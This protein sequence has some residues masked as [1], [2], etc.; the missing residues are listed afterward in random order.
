MRPAPVCVGHKRSIT[1]KGASTSAAEGEAASS[2]HP[3]SPFPRNINQVKPGTI[4][5]VSTP[6]GNL[7]VCL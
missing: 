4:Y 5:F 2:S 1:S 3:A 7:G 6:L